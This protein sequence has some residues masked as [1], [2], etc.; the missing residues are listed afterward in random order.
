MNNKKAAEHNFRKVRLAF[1][2]PKWP[3][4]GKPKKTND[5][6]TDGKKSSDNNEN[7]SD[8][9]KENNG[10]KKFKPTAT[11]KEFVSNSI[12]YQFMGYILNYACN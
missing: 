10:E 2:G 7:G 11:K 12:I 6:D 4:K 3:S 9:N 5:E 1:E 8:K